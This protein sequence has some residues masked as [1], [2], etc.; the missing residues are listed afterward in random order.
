LRTGFLRYSTL[1]NRTISQNTSPV[2]K[3]NPDV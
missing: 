2:K 3:M 1:H